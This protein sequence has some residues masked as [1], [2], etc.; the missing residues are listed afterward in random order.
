MDQAMINQLMA[1]KAG[2]VQAIV[3]E[4]GS[5]DEAVTY[6]VE[7]ARK[8]AYQTVAAPGMDDTQLGLLWR[9]LARP[10]DSPCSKV[11]CTIKPP[12]STLPSRLRT[13]GLPRPVRWY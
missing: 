3:S 2:A 6:T 7:L 11:P 12:E 13:G 10:V 1:D 8:Q 5:F 9:R 4:I